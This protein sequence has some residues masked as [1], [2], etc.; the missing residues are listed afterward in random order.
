MAD[1]TTAKD[2]N[3][4]TGGGATTPC[5]ATVGAPM[6]KRLRPNEAEAVCRAH[7]TS[8]AGLIEEKDRELKKAK[9]SEKKQL[10]KG[11]KQGITIATQRQEI[12]D[13]TW[14]VG[15]I[16]DLWEG[17]NSRLIRQDG[18]IA[19]LCGQIAAQ[20]QEIKDIDDLL[21]GAVNDLDEAHERIEE[22]EETARQAE[23][24][25]VRQALLGAFEKLAAAGVRR[26][27]NPG[28]R[29]ACEAIVQA[30]ENSERSEMLQLI[31]KFDDAARTTGLQGHIATM[32][33]VWRQLTTDERALE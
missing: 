28:E 12:E 25:G 32:N 11:A 26:A 30:L 22:L 1:T 31:R 16:N 13:L 15:V 23:A 10:E 9:M 24:A 4:T 14:E 19:T 7:C 29:A 21:K 18:T 8:M 33:A 2:A 5:T 20:G 6:R 17:A 3:A 27:T